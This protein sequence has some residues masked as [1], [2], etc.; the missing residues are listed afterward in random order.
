MSEKRLPQQPQNRRIY[1]FDNVKTLAIIFVVVG[2]AINFL[3]L[4]P[5]GND[6]EKSLFVFIYSFH[7]PL[8]IFISGLF[9]KPMD[10][11]T[12]FPRGKFISFLLIGIVLRAFTSIIKAFPGRKSCVF[13]S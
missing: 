7:M 9:L 2:H 12:K 4:T 3:A 11:Q 8:F 10:T 13:G 6:L 1:L 5:K